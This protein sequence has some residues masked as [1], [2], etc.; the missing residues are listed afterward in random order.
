MCRGQHLRDHGELAMGMW[1]TDGYQ[2]ASVLE[3]KAVDAKAISNL[4]R[5]YLESVNTAPAI[6]IMI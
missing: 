2:T 1:R 6:I 3:K 5:R 4:C